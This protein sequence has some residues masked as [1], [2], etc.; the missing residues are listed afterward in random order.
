M[1]SNLLYQGKDDGVEVTHFHNDEQMMVTWLY[2]DNRLRV[3]WCS[4]SKNWELFTGDDRCAAQAI[5]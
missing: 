3:E 5:F 2:N 4:G 1:D